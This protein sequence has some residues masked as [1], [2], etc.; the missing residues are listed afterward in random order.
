MIN[1]IDTPIEQCELKF[2]KDESGV[3]EGYASVFGGVDSDGDTIHKGAYAKTL[4]TGRMP[5]MFINHN[6][7][8]IPV[9]RWVGLKE[10]D[11]G[12][13]AR[14]QI[15]MNHRD[16]PSLYSALKTG[17]MTGLSVGFRIFP[18]GAKNKSEGGRDIFDIDLKEISPVTF[19]ADDNARIAVVKADIDEVTNLKSAEMFLRD[20]GLSR[21]MA[22]AFASQFKAVILSESENAKDEQ[23]AKLLMQI[24]ER[25]HALQAHSSTE[26]LVRVINSL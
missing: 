7:Y 21:S 2:S 4:E 8:D 10:D 13:V 20:A 22:T 12:L 1:K 17:A 14:G 5:A 18:E 16:G 9:G 24:K 6:A 25:D 15:D 3:F 23:I 19:P 26:H 11:H